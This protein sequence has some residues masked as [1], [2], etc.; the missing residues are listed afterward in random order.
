ASIPC[1]F[2]EPTTTR[3][4]SSHSGSA[5]WGYAAIGL[6]MDWQAADRLL[7]WTGGKKARVP[8]LFSVADGSP[9]MA[10]AGLWDRWRDPE[11]DEEVLSCTMVVTEAHS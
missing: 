7:E 5:A 8:H 9:V 6:G 11:A 4:V 10:V 1:L 2:G 3:E